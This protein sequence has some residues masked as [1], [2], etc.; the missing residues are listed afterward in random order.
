MTKQAD[1]YHYHNCHN[2]NH[3]LLQRPVEYSKSKKDPQQGLHKKIITSQLQLHKPRTIV[4]HNNKREPPLS[5]S[6]SKLE[7]LQ[8]T[9][10]L[11]K[12][13]SL[14]SVCAAVNQLVEH[15]LERTN[16]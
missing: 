7:I 11:T 6:L 12:F 16:F 1:Y 2:S 8:A 3:S 5:S 4:L 9:P 15:I 13:S 10:P 14:E